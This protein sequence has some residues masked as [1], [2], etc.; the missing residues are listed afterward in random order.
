MARKSLGNAYYGRTA[1]DLID[2]FQEEFDLLSALCARRLR[3]MLVPA[4]GVKVKILNR[5]A[6]DPEG[7]TVLPNLAHGSEAWA[8]LRLDVPRRLAEVAY[9]PV[10]L[11]TATLAYEDM[12]GNGRTATARL[13]L[14][15]LPAAAFEAVA[16]DRVVSARSA[17]LRAAQIQDRARHAA[18]SADWEQVERVLDELRVVSSESPWASAT[19]AGLE[20]YA[21]RPQSELFSKEAMYRSDKMR[22]RLASSRETGD[23]SAKNEAEELSF[24]RRKAEQGRQFDLPKDA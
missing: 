14:A 13:E 7:R 9:D 12:E 22:S 8:L 21:R 4:P 20:E 3:L 1:E 23:W 2:G 19:I 17:E 24:L 15:P 18:R 6:K 16:P 11:L 10:A 5:Y